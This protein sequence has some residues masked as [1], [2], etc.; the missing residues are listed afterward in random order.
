[1]AILPMR[2]NYAGPREA[3][4]HGIIRKNFGCTHLIIGRDHAGVGKYYG[5]YEAQE[6]FD[7]FPDLE[8]QALK[9]EHSF[10]CTKCGSLATAKT[11]PHSG[12]DIVPPSGTK[13]RELINRKELVPEEI[14]R[15]E[16]SELLINAEHPFV[17]G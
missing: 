16:I 9:Y 15:R 12:D 13:I 2:M 4:F 11:C 1:M 6:F 17:E 10:Y 5:T 7:Q 3:I 14:M 8:I